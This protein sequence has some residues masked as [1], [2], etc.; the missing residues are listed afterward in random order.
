[1]P[2]HFGNAKIE[3]ID[4]ALLSIVVEDEAGAYIPGIGASIFSP[5]WFEKNPEK[6]FAVRQQALEDSMLLRIDLDQ[7]VSIYL[8]K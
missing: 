8:V 2:F 1:M 7:M 6:S 3:N 4:C 5:M